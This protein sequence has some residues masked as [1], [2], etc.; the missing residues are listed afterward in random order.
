M[1]GGEKNVR[2]L[3]SGWAKRHGSLSWRA[4]AKE[5]RKVVV[6]WD[7]ECDLWEGRIVL[8]VYVY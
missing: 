8:Y 6:G 7:G 5:V 2:S 4:V 1:V 3:P